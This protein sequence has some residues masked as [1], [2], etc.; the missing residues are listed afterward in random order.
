LTLAT[1]NGN[2]KSNQV[3]EF[4]SFIRMQFPDEMGQLDFG[5]GKL[6]DPLFNF[7]PM[8]VANLSNQM[9]TNQQHSEKRE[10]SFDPQKLEGPPTKK[11]LSPS[12]SVLAFRDPHPT[13]F[14]D[15]Q[16]D[17]WTE[18]FEELCQFVKK[19]EHCLV[20]NS[21]KENPPLAH[22]TKRRK[23]AVYCLYCPCG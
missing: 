19:N 9:A 13:R 4:D 10:L 6:M 14:R 22:W 1:M 2:F 11:P 5:D 15:Y 12:T 23:W 3:V 16:A 21:F 8:S 17:Q 7:P 20:P 18:K